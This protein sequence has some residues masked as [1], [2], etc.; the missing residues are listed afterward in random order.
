MRF[1]AAFA[2]VSLFCLVR[3]N[4]KSLGMFFW[5]WWGNP[6]PAVVRCV[7]RR[8]RR[9]RFPFSHLLTAADAAEGGRDRKTPVNPALRASVRARE[10]AVFPALKCK[11]MGY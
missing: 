8:R 3:R 6:P 1:A 9:F 10:F 7:T 2:R 4:S 5:W 11:A